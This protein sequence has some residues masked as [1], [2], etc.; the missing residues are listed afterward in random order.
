MSNVWFA[1][2]LT[3]FAGMA[4]GIGSALAFLTKR[5]NFRFLSIA[6]GFSAGV[7]LYVS[8]VEIFIKGVDSLVESYG[9]PLG[10]WINAASFFGG[11]A[12]IGIIDALIPHAENP[13][14]IHDS[15]E[16]APLGDPNAPLPTAN[17]LKMKTTAVEE[18]ST[19]HN[20]KLMRMGLFTAL[21]IAIHN[22]PEGLATFLAALEDPS[23]GI[24][25]AIAIALHN[26]PEGISVSVPI[27]YA[28]GNRKKAFF[29]SFLS[30]LAEPV[31]AIIA[32]AALRFFVGGDG[33]VLPP[34]IMGILF[35]GVAGIMV[36][37]SLDE[38]LPTSRAYGK[39]HD[40]LI[41]LVSGM[42]VMALSLLLM[43]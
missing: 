8:F 9:D 21:A 15:Y 3:V 2:G 43:R 37:I 25:I 22:F 41:G 36:Y 20:A 6:T 13:H 19:K 39:G 34:Q 28:T 10:H 31:G 32:Y 1:L 16:V 23:L 33:G 40:S 30:G 7:M 5:T 17:E 14:E 4:T 26:I 27:F 11:M 12:L 38:L 24:P 18:E 29:Y 42:L 35:G